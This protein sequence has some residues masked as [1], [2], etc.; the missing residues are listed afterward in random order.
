MEDDTGNN[1]VKAAREREDAYLEEKIREGDLD[2]N[3]EHRAVKQHREVS[4]Q[5]QNQPATPVSVPMEEAVQTQ[6]EQTMD[7]NPTTWDERLME[8]DFHE[9]VNADDDMYDAIE[10]IPMDQ[11][12]M[13]NHIIGIIH[14]HVSEV[15]S[16]PRVNALAAEYSLTP[17]FSYDIQVND[18]N[19]EPWDFDV[20]AQRAKCARHVMEQK[21]SFLIG[22]PM[23]TAFS[24]LQGLNKWRMKPEKWE[25]LWEKGVRHMR[26]AIKLYKLQ[27][28]N[29]RFFIH[30]HPNSASSWKLPEMVELMEC[31]DIKK[32]V[33]HMCRY[34]MHS[35]DEQGIGMVK[36][37]TGFLSNSEF[38]RTQLQNKCLGGH[39]HIALLGGK[40][41]ACQVYPDK[42]CRAMLKGI[43]DELVHSI[44]GSQSDDMLMVNPEDSAWQEYLDEYVDDVTGKPLIR[45][46]VVEARGAEMEKFRQ[47]KVYTKRPI[48]ECVKVTGKQPIG[49][50]WIDISKG[51]SKNPNYRSRL[52]AQEIKRDNNE[53]MFAATPPLEPKK[54]LFSMAV[55]S[56]ARG[57]CEMSGTQKL[58]FIDVSRAYFYAPSR[59]PV[60]VKL[61]DEDAEPG[62]CGRL[63]VSMYGTR[64]AA[65]NWEEKYSQHL[66]DNGFERGASSP[67]VFYNPARKVRCV[68]HGDD[69][70]FLGCDDQLDFCTKMMTSEYDV[71]IRGRM[72]P[73]A[74]DDKSITI[75][76]RCV[77]WKTDGIH[78]EADPRH[79]EILI[80]ELK[81][82]GT[83]PVVSPGIKSAP[84]PDDQNP[85]LGP[86]QSTKFRQLIARCNFI[87]Q[88]RPDVQNSVKK[89]ARGM[90]NPRK[91]DWEKLVRLGKYLLGKPRYVVVFK[92]QKDTHAINSFGDSDFAGEV[93]TRK[94]TSGGLACLGDHV[95]KSW[96]ST[97]SIIALSTGEAELYAINRSA[98]TALGLQSLLVDLGVQLD[99]RIFTDATT[100]KSIA[101]RRG[102]GKV[103]HIS[104]NELWI[105][106][107]VSTGIITI[108]KIKNKFNPA[109][110]L[111][112]HLSK[113]E[114]AHIVDA[115][116]H[117]FTEG[118]N[119]EAPELATVEFS[120]WID[121]QR[122]VYLMG[123]TTPAGMARPIPSTTH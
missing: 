105:Q 110:L 95:V 4:D 98:A 3:R 114:I 20:P 44:I 52:V 65:A 49:S 112:K 77:E 91:V 46:L 8:N 92:R 35:K 30:E 122:C 24:V 25:A 113:D 87:A 101:T 18:E 81:L 26:F 71:K 29:G 102:L 68:V 34:G 50:K 22:S 94:S 120:E 6:Q 80:R 108:F 36:K 55:T 51:D 66:I 119:S 79:A 42:L 69:F 33:G 93:E 96:S 107:K 118:R 58:L 21:P 2:P 11:E 72:G 5:V 75:L 63:N 109:D 104:V 1:R 85:H 48:S 12:N 39:R 15:W 62:M 54:C 121:S 14:N 100:G 86:E 115:L 38:V 57:R 70:T 64:D 99:I 60:F 73:D 9:V 41:R 90:A 37:P 10:A 19:G 13:V 59:R 78:Y 47:H 84:V 106:E 27:A 23:C 111:T 83:K 88:D 7:R 32:V 82:E 74:K 117:Q 31:L 17:G 67:C 89:I 16:P 53:D 61:P 28:E 76:N 116:G 56:F 40:A 103:R 97:Q 43:R 45:E 123:K